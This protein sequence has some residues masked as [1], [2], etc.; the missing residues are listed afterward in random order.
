MRTLTGVIAV[1]G[2]SLMIAACKGVPGYV[3]QPDEMA[4]LLADRHVAEAVVDY[5]PSEWRTDSQRIAL[6]DAVYRRYGVTQADVDTSLDWYGHNIARYMDVYD[7]TIE[8]LETRVASSDSRLKAEMTLTM[9]GDSVDVWP[10]SR[11]YAIV[12]TAPSRNIAFTLNSDENREWG[13]CYTWRAKFANNQHEAMWTMVAEY[14]DSTAEFLTERV[15]GS[16]WKEI[17]LQTDSSR[18]ATRIYGSLMLRPGDHTPMWLDSIALVR[19]HLRPDTYQ[20]RSR[21]RF[22]RP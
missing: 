11:Y 18:T 17:S 21:Q 2:L 12:P 3:I 10:L 19:N 14:S 13:D 20:R 4:Q 15:N 1:A 5:N 9:A 22:L 8:I 6:R 7:R 16:G